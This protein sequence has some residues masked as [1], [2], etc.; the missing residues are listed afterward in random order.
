MD[1]LTNLHTRTSYPRVS[2]PIPD[3]AIIDNI[4]NAALRAPDHGQL[5]PWRFLRIEG[6]SLDRLGH[7]FSEAAFK[8]DP[9]LDTEALSKIADKAKRAPLVI[10]TVSRAAPHPKIP[11]FEQDLSAAAATQSMLLAAHAQGIGAVW[12]TGPMAEHPH[13]LSGLGLTANEKLIAFLFI[14][15]PQGSAKTIKPLALNDFVKKW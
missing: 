4:F 10:L 2:G 14:G 15:F 3:E 13:V 11:E 8:D 1:A 5:R 12:R 7:L 6:E 9:S